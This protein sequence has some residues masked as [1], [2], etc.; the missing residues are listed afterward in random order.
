LILEQFNVYEKLETLE[1]MIE[2]QP[3]GSFGVPLSDI[4]PAT[5]MRFLS[6]KRKEEECER[7]AAWLA[8]LEK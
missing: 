7:L 3:E 5:A 2:Q 1:R 4:R 6:C 8:R